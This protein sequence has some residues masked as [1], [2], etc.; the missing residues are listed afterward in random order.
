MSTA[1]AVIAL[2]CYVRLTMLKNARGW[3]WEDTFIMLGYA[4]FIGSGGTAVKSAFYG[5]GTRDSELNAF[6]TVRCAEYMLYSQLFYG[7]S[8][9]LIKASVVIMLLRFTREKKYRWTLYVM[10]FIA[11]TMALVGILSL[12]LFCRPIK[13]YWNPLLGKCGRFTTLIN[14]GY[15]W[16]AVGIATDWTCSIIPWFVVHKLHMS[17]RTKHTITVILGLGSLASTATIV[18]APYI[19]YYSSPTDRLYWTGHLS[20][21]C[22]VESGLGL[23]S[24]SLPA[25]RFLLA[26]WLETSRHGSGNKSGS[27]SKAGYASGKRQG[28]ALHTI[29]GGERNPGMPL[30]TLAPGGK[31]GWWNRL[32]DDSSDKGIIVQET[33]VIESSSLS[34]ADIDIG[35][36]Q[37]M[38]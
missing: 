15:T 29:G 24:A 12:L 21:W 26:N 16:T 10:Q 3:T 38:R 31:D 30:N 9:P 22:T 32:E 20:I 11:T 33:I 27:N 13:A 2:R 28:S 14:I 23:I 37:R 18:R 6:L 34:E 36:Q 25:L 1:T 19:K 8:M 7:I 4:A 17:R 5:L 35:R